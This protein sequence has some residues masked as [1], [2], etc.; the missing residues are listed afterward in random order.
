[1]EYK[2]ILAEVLENISKNN[3]NSIKTGF[4]DI[5][6]MLS[7]IEKGSLVIIGGRPAMGKTSFM[8]TILENL[9]KAGHKCLYFSVELSKE[10]LIRR[11]LCQCS[12]VDYRKLSRGKVSEKDWEKITEV[13]DK[14]SDYDF[15]IDDTARL[16]IE[17]FEEK[18]KEI[19]PEYVF[20]D[21]LQFMDANFILTRC[22]VLEK[23]L[24][25]I[26][27]IAKEN[28]MFVFMASQL[29]RAIESRFDKR[30]ML[31]DLRESAMIEEVA[32]VVMFIYRD[33]YYQSHSDD[34]KYAS[35]KGQAEIIIA[36]NKSG[37]VGTV[38]LLF[39]DS[40]PKFYETLKIV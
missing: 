3:I 14:I 34:E 29:S 39:I 31:C 36:K 20:I 10:M 38:K 19:K 35:N 5:D 37:P 32:D 30:P 21:Y 11:F 6:I 15:L 16:T 33:E 22:D 4:E 40:I 23:I 7:G 13:L 18:I 25:G 17:M 28:N 8:M 24:V 1:M 9:L 26:K 2:E 27:R 12:E